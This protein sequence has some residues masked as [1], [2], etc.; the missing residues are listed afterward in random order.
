[1]LT[2]LINSLTGWDRVRELGA[3]LEVRNEQIQYL[4][5]ELAQERDRSE[6]EIFKLI[7]KLEEFGYDANNIDKGYWE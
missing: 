2:K 7:D 4:K 3:L 6:I 5:Q 1:M